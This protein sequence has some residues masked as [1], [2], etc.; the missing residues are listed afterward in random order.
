MEIHQPLKTFPA[1]LGGVYGEIQKFP[2]RREAVSRR[3]KTACGLRFC[4]KVGDCV[5]IL[6]GMLYKT[7]VE[8]DDRGTADVVAP[9]SVVAPV[10][11]VEFAKEGV[12]EDI[13]IA[14]GT[15]Y[16]YSVIEPW[17]RNE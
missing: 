11:E 16:F 8:L 3:S 5:L 9:E 4:P 13:G 10:A 1:M 7:P 17:R 15:N 14:R 2:F 12:V 6:R